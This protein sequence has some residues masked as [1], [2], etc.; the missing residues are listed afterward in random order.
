MGA[1]HDRRDR[2]RRTEH[3]DQVLV[4]QAELTAAVDSREWAVLPLSLTTWSSFSDSHSRWTLL[5]DS[6]R[7]GTKALR[8]RC[9][10]RAAIHVPAAGS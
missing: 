4:V 3:H 1:F 7:Q 10:R 6:S 2:T 8:L 9:L 5:Q